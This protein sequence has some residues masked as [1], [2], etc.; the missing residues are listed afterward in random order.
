MILRWILRI[1]VDDLATIES[2]M[3]NEKKGHK[4]TK[5]HLSRKEAIERFSGDELKQA[6]MSR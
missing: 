2:K 4:L 5:I 1:G 3:E 6:V